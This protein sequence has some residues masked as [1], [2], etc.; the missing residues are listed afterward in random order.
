MSTTWGPLAG[1]RVLEIASIGPGPLATM[2]LADMGADVVRVDRPVS[3]DRRPPPEHDLL[4]RGRRSVVIDLKH[5]DGPPTLLLLVEQADA[6]VEG[7][8]PGVAE[9]LGIGPHACLTRNRR[10]IYARITGWGQ[11]GPYAQMAGHDINYV[12]LAGVLHAIGRR[13]APPTP[14]LN[15]VGD[16]G[17]GTLLAFGVL[18]G[19]LEA[20]QSGRGQVIDAAM[21]DAAAVLATHHYALHAIGEWSDERG[22]NRLDSGYPAYDVYATADGKYVAVGALEP[23]F[24][25]ELVQRLGLRDL[26]SGD[27]RANWDEIR[28]RFAEAFAGRTRDEWAA[29]FEGSDVCVTPVLSFDEAPAHPHNAARATFV[30]VNGACQPAPAPRFSRTPGRIGARPPAP[31][32]HTRAALQDWGIAA[33]EVR[34]LAASGAIR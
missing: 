30:D 10:L 27:Y 14:A 29:C 4:N 33:E 28:Q 8:R 17:G 7:L 15:L 32:Q 11:T 25:H 23:A 21:V 16:Y 5:P 20:R 3:L 19:I 2:L 1:L 13:G 34:R 18:C 22:T 9:R 12:A 26:P 6:L 24:Y 31:G